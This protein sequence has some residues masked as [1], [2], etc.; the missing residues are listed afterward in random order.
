MPMQELEGR[1]WEGSEGRE[2]RETVE[3]KKVR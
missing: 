3:T 2:T 1:I